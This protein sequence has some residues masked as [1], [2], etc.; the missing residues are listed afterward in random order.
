[1]D[2]T[3]SRIRKQAVTEK[4][5]SDRLEETLANELLPYYLAKTDPASQAASAARRE[6]YLEYQGKDGTLLEAAQYPELTRALQ[7]KTKTFNAYYNVHYTP[8]PIILVDGLLRD[9]HTPMSFRN[10]AVIIDKEFFEKHHN[11]SSFT[12]GI[13]HEL[14][15][16]YNRDPKVMKVVLKGIELEYD[17]SPSEIKISQAAESVADLDAHRASPKGAF[18]QFLKG[19]IND[20]HDATTLGYFAQKNGIES[21]EK[22]ATAFNSLKPEALKQWQSEA[23]ALPPAQQETYFNKGVQIVDALD[24]DPA[25]PKLKDRLTLQEALDKYP[26]VLGCRI[27]QFTETNITTATDCGPKHVPLVV[28]GVPTGNRVR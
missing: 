15:H 9:D 6:E 14:S 4:W 22:A 7:E 21:P 10:D 24:G 25:H 2:A 19:A 3:Q 28:D 1:M 11:E 18:A 13:A 20:V 23:A 12:A 17:I 26:A 8:P 16:R 27:I 5:S